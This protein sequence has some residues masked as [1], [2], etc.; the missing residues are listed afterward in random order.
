MPTSSKQFL[1]VVSIFSWLWLWGGVTIIP[2]NATVPEFTSP[3]TADVQQSHPSETPEQNHG[4]SRG[5]DPQQPFHVS[6]GTDTEHKQKF[7]ESPELVVARCEPKPGS[8]LSASPLVLNL[9]R[10]QSIA[11]A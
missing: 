9:E 2:A 3:D 1:I 6:P 4:V 10:P 7:C 11:F 8:P 5:A